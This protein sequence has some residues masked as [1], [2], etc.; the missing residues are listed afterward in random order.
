MTPQDRS[1][2]VGF[3]GILINVSL[4]VA[5]GALIG[6][7]PGGQIGLIL[8]ICLSI[9]P[10]LLRILAP[11][12]NKPKGMVQFLAR[13]MGAGILR[14]AGGLLD[15]L[16][17]YLS[18]LATALRGVLLVGRLIVDLVA[19]LLGPPLGRIGSALATPL[20][21]ANLAALAVIAANLAGL[22]FAAPVAFLGLGMLVLVLI[23]SEHEARTAHD[24]RAQGEEK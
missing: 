12:F 4:C 23:V 24:A 6:G 14:V 1:L 18:P 8:G 15:R 22:D 9:L 16:Q 3:G 5:L 21:L 17:A 7:L 13:E 20:G 10:G 11:L 2:I 19:G